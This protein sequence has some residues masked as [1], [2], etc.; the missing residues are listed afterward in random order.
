MKNRNPQ[1][2]SQKSPLETISEITRLSSFDFIFSKI[3]FFF[4]N[5][6]LQEAFKPP[7]EK[8]ASYPRFMNGNLNEYHDFSYIKQFHDHSFVSKRC[9][10]F[11][12]F[13]SDFLIFFQNYPLTECYRDHQFCQFQR[14][15]SLPGTWLSLGKW[16]SRERAMLSLS[17]C[18]IKFC[19]NANCKVLQ[20]KTF[21]VLA[22]FTTFEL[23][24]VLMNTSKN[25]DS[26]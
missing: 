22:R 11:K 5:F 13:Q 19:C 20:L 23:A 26:I 10:N 17:I 15:K 16:Y 4:F 24:V 2:L 9:Y 25:L 3:I 14:R 18:E 21:T 8:W 7:G 12:R 1:T 6:H